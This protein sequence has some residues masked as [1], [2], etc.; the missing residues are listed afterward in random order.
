VIATVQQKDVPVAIRSIGNVETI[1]GVGIKSLISGEI[2]EVHF[3]EGQDVNKGDLLF[4]I[5]PRQPKADLAKAESQLVRDQATANNSRVQAERYSKLLQEGVVAKQQYDQM[6]ASSQADTATV[7]ADRA[8][9]D[10]AKLQLAYTKIYSPITGRTGNLAVTRGNIVKANDVPVL[11]TINQVSPIYVT[12]S[13]PETQLGDVKK[14]MAARQ[15]KVEAMPKDGAGVAAGQLTFVDNGVDATTG[16]IKLKGTFANTDRKLWPGQFVDVLLTLT[17][18]PNAIVVPS[19]AVQTGQNGQF[20]YIVKSD[21]TVDMRPVKL[22][23][24]DGQLAVIASGLSA[25]ER[26]VTDGQLRLQPGSRVEV[27]TGTT[28]AQPTQLPTSGVTATP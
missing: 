1:N 3:K 16:T 22:K 26:V 25:G 28:N 12:F 10:N 19:Q 27:K 24:T 7:E 6:V 11:V 15:V 17:T 5:D 18:E 14:Y 23:R 2:M 21:S 20:V 8:A 9:V 13:V 4:E